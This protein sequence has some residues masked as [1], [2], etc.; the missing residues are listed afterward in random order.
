VKILSGEEG[1]EKEARLETVLTLKKE[2]GME[3]KVSTV[4]GDWKNVQ[5]FI[6]D[7]EHIFLK[8][9]NGKSQH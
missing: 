6:S 7:F 4:C 1:L 8:G 3:I 2:S 9:N 5:K